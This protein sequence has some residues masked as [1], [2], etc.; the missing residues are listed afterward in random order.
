[1]CKHQLVSYSR[2]QFCEQLT[3]KFQL[4]YTKLNDN[5]VIL[6]CDAKTPQVVDILITLA[7]R[8]E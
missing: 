4:S 3:V 7:L 2:L 1:M 6:W 5:K 8:M